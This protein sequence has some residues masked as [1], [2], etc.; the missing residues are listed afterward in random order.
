MS[1]D[2]ENPQAAS[3][4][5]LVWQACAATRQARERKNGHRGAVVWLTGLPGSGKSTL[6]RG[7][8]ELLHHGGFQ[9]ALLD[10]D[11]LR[12]GLCADLGFSLADRNENVRRV[13]E[14]AK[15]LLD[16]GM[17]VF[18]ALVSPVREAREQVRQGLAP[19]DF[20]EIHCDCP[21]SV[22]RERDPKGMY[23]KAERGAIAEFTGVSSPYEAPLEA[24]LVLATGVEGIEESLSRLSGYLLERL[25]QPA[26]APID[27]AAPSRID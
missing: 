10:G 2:H 12:H 24:S 9:T 8:E 13:G 5:N 26:P 18:V 6:A 14:V 17:V 4:R 1:I 22:C 7:V 20:L 3:A 16:L 19:G 11:N 15:L 27:T 23:A 21:L 25:G